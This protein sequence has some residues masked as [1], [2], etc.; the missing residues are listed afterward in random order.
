MKVKFYTLGCKVNQYETQALMEEFA[1]YGFTIT[2]DKAD[3]CVI[4]TCSVTAKAD[5]KSRQIILRAKKENPNAKIAVSGCL[6]QLDKASIPGA[7]YIISQDSKHILADTIAVSEGLP[8]NKTPK[9]IWSLKING[10]FNSR[11]FVKIQDGCDNICSFCKIP[12]IRGTTVSRPQD[13]TIQEIKRLL[14]RHPEIILTGINLALYGKDLKPA[15]SLTAIIQ[16]I[17][18]MESLGRLRLSSLEPAAINTAI[19]GLFRD[20]KM[21]PHVHLPFQAGDDAILKSMNK[22]VSTGLYLELVRDFRQVAPEIAIS[23]DI[24]VGFPG[25]NEKTFINTISFLEKVRPMRAHIFTFSGRE[26]T[27]YQGWRSKDPRT[28][29]KRAQVLK[30]LCASF[31]RQYEQAYCGKPLTMVTEEFENGWTSGYTENYLRVSVNK[32]LPLGR[33]L[34]IRLLEAKA[35]KLIAET[36]N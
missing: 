5:S 10:F 7:D 6:A 32:R 34:P 3:L 24:M 12:H 9:D 28:T 13:A 4:N 15:T 30:R 31:S 27:K 35:Q 14:P 17:L 29:A 26:G 1:G 23:C 2:Q 22:K 21:C 16:S 25:E 19:L 20:P 11:A 8:V 36:Y 18:S 33:L